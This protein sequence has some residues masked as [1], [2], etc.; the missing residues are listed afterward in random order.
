MSPY[1]LAWLCLIFIT[2]AHAKRNN[3]CRKLRACNQFITC[4]SSFEQLITDESKIDSVCRTLPH[5]IRCVNTHEKRCKN[6]HARY[7]ANSVRD[8]L[9][10]MCTDAG[11]ELISL[12][13]SSQCAEDILSLE[14]R[15]LECIDEFE[16]E[17]SEDAFPEAIT[18]S[19]PT[20]TPVSLAN[21]EPSSFCV[22]VDELDRCLIHGSYKLCG[23]DWGTFVADVWRIF[24]R[25][26]M[27]QFGC[28]D[29]RIRIRRSLSWARSMLT[30]K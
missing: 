4:C 17:I 3:A 28:N 29:R 2:A 21:S 25:D 12:M 27:S 23:N 24:S 22:H 26:E 13:R 1:R 10:Y 14:M 6:K 9:Q 20:P 11:R 8:I 19:P 5:V 30:Q 16:V 18:G 15:V 7:D